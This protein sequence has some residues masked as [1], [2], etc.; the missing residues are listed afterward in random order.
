MFFCRY[1]HT[2]RHLRPIQIFGR[3]WFRLYT[4]KLG[5]RLATPLVRNLNNYW[6]MPACRPGS[7]VAPECFMLLGERGC[8]AEVGWTGNQCAKLWRYNQHYFDDLNAHNADTRREWHHSLLQRWIAENPP[9]R[10]DGWEPYPTSLRIVNWVKW[11]FSG[12]QL[13]RD[14]V[15]NLA[16]QARW[17]SKR[18]EHHLLG[19]HLFANAKALIFVGTFFCGKEAAVWLAKGLRI[20]KT[21]IPEQILKDGGQFE[22]STMYHALALEDM[23]DLSNVLRK[24]VKSPDEHSKKMIGIIEST[25]EEI[26]LRIPSM[27]DW[28]GTMSHPD[29]EIAFFNDAAF[30]V[31]PSC[32]ELFTYAKRLGFKRCELLAGAVATR[33][34]SGYIR[35]ENAEACLFFDVATV[36]PN[37]LPGHAHA[38]TL[39]IELSLFGKRVFVNSGTSEYGTTK[40]RNRQR[41]TAAHN[42]LEING[43]SSSEVWSGFR[44]ARRA[45]PF[46]VHAA[47]KSACLLATAWQ[48]GYK[49]LTSPVYVGRRVTLAESYLQ[50]EDFVEGEFHTAVSRFHCHPDVKPEL[51]SPNVVLLK[52]QD[53]KSAWLKAPDGAVLS[54][55]DTTWHPRFGERISNRCIEISLIANE[56]VT[57]I[58]WS[59]F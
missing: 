21:E 8:L 2:L 3:L 25:L 58:E 48:D 9:S 35:L 59:Q 16:V 20:L 14:C 1:Y 17:L 45:F 50:I 57:R 49:R 5:K 54:I 36:G 37:Y 13:S 29:N 51:L 10:G 34:A 39:S 31:A 47:E 42:T 40:E 23:L 27:I 33:K 32:S 46:K 52:L 7:L 26:E 19:N 11:S 30:D 4:P 15:N 41:S 55:Y 53:G 12:N 22:L 38:D 6:V 18:L 43:E 44:V 24:L 56:S 28:L